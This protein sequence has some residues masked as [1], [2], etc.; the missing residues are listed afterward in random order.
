VLAGAAVAVLGAFASLLNPLGSGGG[1]D[2]SGPAGANPSVFVTSAQGAAVA[3]LGDLESG[4]ASLATPPGQ[5][6][7]AG[8]VALSVDASVAVVGEKSCVTPP[9]PT[10][11]PTTIPT[12]TTSSSSTTTTTTTPTTTTTTTTIPTTLPTTVPTTLPTTVP[13]T[14]PTTTP[15]TPPTQGPFRAG[16]EMAVICTWWLDAISVNA[17]SVL[18][19][20]QLPAE[21]LAIAMAPAD[22]GT[23]YVLESGQIQSFD[24]SSCLPPAVSCSPKLSGTYALGSGER[25][26]SLAISPNGSSLYLGGYDSSL[27]ADFIDSIP[28]ASFPPAAASVSAWQLPAAMPAGVLSIATGPGGAKV[29]AGVEASGSFYVVALATPL[30]T[31]A[32]KW[33]QPE[34]APAACPTI[35]LAL[36]VSPDGSTV[37][38]AGTAAS[39]SASQVQYLDAGSG[40]VL[41]RCAGPIAGT[42]A[43]VSVSATGSSLL[44]SA[45]SSSGLEVFPISNASASVGKPTVLSAG[46]G[47]STQEDVAIAPVQSPPVASFSLTS[48]ASTGATVFDAASSS[49]SCGSITSYAWSFGD[50]A[51]AKSSS[52]S[53]SHSY[54]KPGLYTVK[55]VVTSSSPPPGFPSDEPGQTATCHAPDSASA[56]KV[57]TISSPTLSLSPSIGPPGTVVTVTGSGFPPN[58]AVTVSWSVSSGSVAVTSTA[59]GTL[60]PSVLYILVPDVLGPR[61]AVSSAKGAPAAQAG[62]LVVPSTAEP[63]GSRNH[64]LFRSEGP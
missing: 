64:Y 63:G 17:A 56:S 37:Y 43:G 61:Q 60:P 4:A 9:P 18:G 16:T 10:T 57:V 50:G 24:I 48:P 36:T 27:A 25:G 7:S 52:P 45:L 26:Q 44:V 55:L 8:P 23:G 33:S 30:P 22:P 14:L 1:S 39:G 32:T 38:V 34:Q 51:T 46:P 5:S 13:T 53:V 41:G 29:F 15:T 42:A 21:P 40:S 54:A 58:T 28:L 19:E 59:S 3:A 31:S 35:P 6:G 11:T 2:S 47:Y 12:T 62:F 20:V 49:A